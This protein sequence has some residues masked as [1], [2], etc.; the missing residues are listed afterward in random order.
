MQ[1]TWLLEGE[2][3]D[4]WRLIGKITPELQ[5]GAAA[6]GGLVTTIAEHHRVIYVRSYRNA[7][8]HPVALDS[9]GGFWLNEARRGYTLFVA[10]A[11][12]PPPEDAAEGERERGFTLENAATIVRYLVFLGVAVVDPSTQIPGDATPAGNLPTV[13]DP[14]DR[15]ILEM[16]RKDPDLTDQ[17]IGQQIGLSRQAVNA[18]RRKL[19]A[20]GFRVR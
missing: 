10:R 19:R 7:A 15:R 11:A 16:V 14:T 17:A 20:M 18:R 4:V 3:A 13:T 9:S 8:G 1:R 12:D 5:K 2:I 6:D